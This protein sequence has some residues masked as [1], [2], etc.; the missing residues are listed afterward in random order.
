MAHIHTYYFY[1]GKSGSSLVTTSMRNPALLYS[2]A[3]KSVFGSRALRGPLFSFWTHF[4]DAD[5][6]AERLAE[7]TVA[8][9]NEYDLDLVKTAPNGMY[10]VEDFGVEIDFSQVSLGGVARL[11]STPYR[12]AADW[13]GLPEPDIFKGALGREL[14]SLKLVRAALPNVP[15]VFTVF[16]PITVAAKLSGGAVHGHIKAGEGAA[17]HE[18]LR[19][20]TRL[21]I[22]YARAA[23]AA[24]ADGIFFAH[25]D[26]SR[27]LLGH[28]A[29]SEYVAPYDVEVLTAAMA[30]RF[31]VLHLHGKSIRFRELQD[32]PVHAVNWHSWETLPSVSAGALTSGKCV[33]GGIDR[34]S[35]TNN[36]VPAI[37]EQIAAAIGTMA[38]IGDLLLAPSC[39]IRAGFDPATIRSMRDLARN[40]AL[41]PREGLQSIPAIQEDA[42][43]RNENVRLG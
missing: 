15:I 3:I 8:L 23:L 9:Q 34:R 2:P 31:N 11:V 38:A 25:Q 16:S 30:G 22:H 27:H 43:P 26:T 21:T 37:A 41:L 33:V 10:A 6:D 18:A 28:D 20:L 7:K 35:I 14:H 42:G 1:D 19:R 32:Y 40:Q 29:F 4:P 17:V 24:G 13:A 39:T 12:T 36:D 5:M